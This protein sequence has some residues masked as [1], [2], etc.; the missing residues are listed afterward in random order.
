VVTFFEIISKAGGDRLTKHDSYLAAKILVDFI[1]DFN[2]LTEL[3]LLAVR[4]LM[5]QT[6]EG[7]MNTVSEM[8]E[9]ADAKKRQAQQILRKNEAGGDF[10][11]FLLSDLGDDDLKGISQDQRIELLEAKI[12]RS[13][14]LFSKHMKAIHLLSA[15]M[16]ELVLSVVGSLS[17][18]DVLG[19]RLTHAMASIRILKAALSEVISKYEMYQ[20]PQEVKA[21]RNRVLNAVYTTYTSED[22]REVFHRVFGKPRGTKVLNAC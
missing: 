7:V 13:G 10:V 8:S 6:V 22:D 18:D 5:R 15:D 12:R 20:Q 3:Q 16:Q 14:G 21:L 1:R 2:L 11:P 17:I 19:Q 9:C 4:H